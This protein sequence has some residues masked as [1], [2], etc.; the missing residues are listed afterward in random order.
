MSWLPV[1]EIPDVSQHEEGHGA[2]LGNGIEEF[3]E[4]GLPVC[5]I[6]DIQAKVDVRNEVDK[7]A[8][9]HSDK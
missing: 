2:V 6:V 4:T 1:P 8:F 9:S 3:H 7:G 5:R